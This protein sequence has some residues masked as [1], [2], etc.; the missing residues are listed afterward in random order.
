MHLH[1]EDLDAI[2]VEEKKDSSD[3]SQARGRGRARGTMKIEDFDDNE[4]PKD[5]SSVTGYNCQKKG[6][7]ANECR[8]LN[9]ET[10]KID[11]EKL[12]K[13]TEA[14]LS[15]KTSKMKLKV[16]ERRC[17]QILPHLKTPKLPHLRVNLHN[18][19]DSRI[20][21]N[22]IHTTSKIQAYW[23]QSLSVDHYLATRWLSA[24]LSNFIDKGQPFSQ[25][26][27]QNL[28]L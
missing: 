14:L 4:R 8:F 15:L 18:M 1:L 17:L 19:K 25:S 13:S 23:T 11:K 26:L 9:K 27:L 3:S 10:P 5:K 16:V 7:Y 20:Y 6:H 21:L 24:V 28:N 22:Y 2:S 12:T